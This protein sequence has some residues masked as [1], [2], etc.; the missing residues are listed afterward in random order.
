[1]LLAILIVV[2][3][4]DVV[5]PTASDGRRLMTNVDCMYY[6]SR[7]LVVVGGGDGPSHWSVAGQRGQ[8]GY[9][10]AVVRNR[11][12]VILLLLQYLDSCKH[13]CIT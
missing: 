7:G 6:S 2:D 5:P 11:D 4:V 3:V 9:G 12:R 10:P 1:M 8:A 13:P